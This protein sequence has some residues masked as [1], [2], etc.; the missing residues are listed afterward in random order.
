M[1]LS[2]AY[3]LLLWRIEYIVGPSM[4]HSQLMESLVLY[5]VSTFWNTHYCVPFDPF[6]YH[7]QQQ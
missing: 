1:L 5:S 6:F 7:P 3:S 2:E 4:E